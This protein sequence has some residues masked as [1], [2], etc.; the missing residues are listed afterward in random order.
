M[1]YLP[2]RA[3]T[4][5]TVQGMLRKMNTEYTP[6][7]CQVGYTL[8]LDGDGVLFL[9]PLVGE[10]IQLEYTGKIHCVACGR[11][12]VK[13]FNSGY[14][15]PCFK[16]LAECDICIVRPEKCHF[17]L[18]TC[19]D[20]VWGKNHCFQTHTLYLAR[21]GSIKIGIT[22]TVQQLHRWMDQGASEARE[23]GFFENR[24]QVGLAEAD[25]SRN[26]KDKTNWQKML[27]NVTTTESFEYYF[28]QIL[29]WLPKELRPSLV[30]HG[31][32]YSFSYPVLAY[33]QKVKSKKLDEFPSFKSKLMGIKGQYLIFEG[34][35]F[36]LRSH[37]G[38][39][40]RLSY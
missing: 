7:S 28:Q 11:S 1:V 23:I 10:E 29:S 35:V 25:I 18:G 5:P 15:Y 9:N 31:K 37:G 2:H 21:S 33:P 22:R 27:K 24:Y 16:G 30:H 26:M 17:H 19:R 12:V 13:T 20:P 6:Q 38:Y 3:F 8:N 14:C 36:N 34:H 39:L 40:I 32:S 4:M